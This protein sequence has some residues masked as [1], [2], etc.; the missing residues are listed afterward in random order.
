MHRLLPICS[1]L[2]WFSYQLLYSRHFLP[3]TFLQTGLLRPF[4]TRRGLTDGQ[5]CLL[6]FRIFNYRFNEFARIYKLNS[7]LS[8]PNTT[9]LKLCDFYIFK[10]RF[11]THLHQQSQRLFQ[12]F[13]PLTAHLGFGSHAW[14]QPF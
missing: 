14:L 11:F 1:R 9:K 10:F 8:T 12:Y 3:S 13:L 4:F 6:N 2:S 7:W 5:S